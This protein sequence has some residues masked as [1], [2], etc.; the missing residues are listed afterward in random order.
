MKVKAK[1]PVMRETP[2]EE[3]EAIRNMT[4]AQI[5][6][7]EPSTASLEHAEAV[8]L[9]NKADAAVRRKTGFDKIDRAYDKQTGI[10]SSAADAVLRHPAK[11]I[12]GLAAKE[13]VHRIWVFNGEDFNYI[14]D[15]IARL[16][17]NDAI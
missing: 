17:S 9:W 5:G 3:I 12:A 6:K 15:D 11:T 14:L 8:L 7:M 2:P 1:R 13:R 4:I 16:T 10:T